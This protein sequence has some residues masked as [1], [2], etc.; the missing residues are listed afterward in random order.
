MIGNIGIASQQ[1]AQPVDLVGDFL[2]GDDEIEP[3]CLGVV[4]NDDPDD[5]T[6][7]ID[8]RPPAVP[9]VKVHGDIEIVQTGVHEIGLIGVDHACDDLEVPSHRIACRPDIVEDL[10]LVGELHIGKIAPSGYL[11]DCPVTS[12]SPMNDIRIVGVAVLQ[13]DPDR[14]PIAQT[15]LDDMEVGADESCL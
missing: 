6:V 12:R 15:I 5:I 11:Q 7:P 3:P 4:G 9:A 8:H 10:R 14:I 13:P 1:I 2:D